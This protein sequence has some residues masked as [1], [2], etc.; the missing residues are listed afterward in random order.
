[1][2]EFAVEA[3]QALWA[4][5]KGSTPNPD[6]NLK[7]WDSNQEFPCSVGTFGYEMDSVE[8]YKNWRGVQCLTNFECNISTTTTG[9]INCSALVIGL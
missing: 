8:D 3:L 7:G 9:D 5:W 2:G 6:V 1:M 4:A